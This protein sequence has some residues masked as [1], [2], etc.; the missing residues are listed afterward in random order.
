MERNDKEIRRKMGIGRDGG[1]GGR[2][3]RFTSKM[4]ITKEIHAQT[5]TYRTQL[6]LL[7]PHS[8]FGIKMRESVW[9]EYFINIAS[10]RVDS[11][12]EVVKG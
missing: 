6:F 4:E 8:Y 11:L 7:S 12:F 5:Q 3:K 10:F 9:T 2:C 1:Y